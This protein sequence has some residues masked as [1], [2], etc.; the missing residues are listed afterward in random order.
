MGNLQ[1]KIQLIL[2]S[3]IYNLSA[4]EKNTEISRHLMKK[5]F[6]WGKSSSIYS[7]CT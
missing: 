3:G 5:N 2:N 4:I 6:Q 1:E 7:Y